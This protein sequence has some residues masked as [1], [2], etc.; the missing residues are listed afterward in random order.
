M[1]SSTR[2]DARALAR[3]IPVAALAAACALVGCGLDAEVGRL[4]RC[5]LGIRSLEI[6]EV[7]AELGG[8]FALERTFHQWNDV[9]PTEAERASAAAGRTI[10]ASFNGKRA[11]GDL[12]FA[13][14]A[15]RADAEVAGDL[16]AMAARIRAYGAPI[17][18]VFHD[19][20]DNDL[21]FGTPA[22]FVAAW[23]R[24]VDAFRAAGADNAIWVWSLS[25]KAY[26]SAADAW[27]PGDDYVDRIGVTG[28][29]WYN[30]DPASPW[31]T[32]ASIFASFFEWSRV[33]PRPL[34]IVSTA[35]GENPASAP[36]G[37]QNKPTWIREAL[38]T[39]VAEPRLQAVVWFGE[40]GTDELRDWRVD[41]S[42]AS[43][44]AFRELF[45]DPHF[46]LTGLTPP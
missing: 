15:D 35:A 27:Y 24:V 20:A 10:V 17:F 40:A 3:A 31:R 11:A 5:A 28:F 14:I 30:A 45:D 42:A 34:M 25:A 4:E 26:P 23:R 21:R 33:H 39:I 36:G 19:E 32:F 44:A 12:S 9:F 38:A 1:R 7:E 6:D 22:E 18:L 16:A 13:R 46:D 43:L 37:T 2:G 29:N 41:S 8:K